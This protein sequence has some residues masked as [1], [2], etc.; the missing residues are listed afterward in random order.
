[1]AKNDPKQMAN[2]ADPTARPSGLPGD[3]NNWPML[4]ITYRTK[5][6]AIAALLP[7]GIEPMETS[8]VTLTIYNLPVPDEPEY[9]IIVT[10]DAIY[11]GTPG[12]YCLA[13]GIDQESPII[14]AQITSSQPKFLCDIEYYLHGS[15]VVARC[16]HQGYTF[17]E[18]AGDI[19]DEDP[20]QEESI[21]RNEWWVKSSKSAGFP[22]E[23]YDCEPHVVHVHGAYGPGYRLKIDNPDLELM[24]S[25]WDPIERLLPMEEMVATHLWWPEYRGR[26]IKPAGPL[27][28]D[29]FDEFYK[30][31][32]ISGSRWPGAL[33]GPR[34]R[35]HR[36]GSTAEFAGT[37]FYEEVKK[38]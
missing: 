4:K 25:P 18:F 11:D 30:G 28:V 23:T 9:G 37:K 16:H 31:G 20:I 15:R 14:T 7:P 21:E 10:I 19:G 12:E 6:E 1:M 29:A 38:V 13:Y 26:S 8:N 24:Y 35:H 34:D 36:K 33:G 2:S 22:S 27:D 32:Y 5:P 17:L 3:I